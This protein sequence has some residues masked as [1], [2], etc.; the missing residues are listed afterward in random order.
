MALI[1]P[2]PAYVVIKLYN[3]IYC[4]TIEWSNLNGI[5]QIVTYLGR[6]L[7]IMYLTCIL[8]IYLDNILPFLLFHRAF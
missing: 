4:N 6:T 8:E 7:R 1:G 2:L 5:E 3:K